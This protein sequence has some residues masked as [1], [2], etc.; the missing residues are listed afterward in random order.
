[1]LIFGFLEVDVS[2]ITIVLLN[3]L[4]EYVNQVVHNNNKTTIQLHFDHKLI[5]KFTFYAKQIVISDKN[6]FERTY[7]AGTFNK[8]GLTVQLR[9]QM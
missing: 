2:C 8:L 3:F 1:M 7:I 6:V 5:D 4:L 9:K